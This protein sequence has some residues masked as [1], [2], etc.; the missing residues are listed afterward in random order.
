MQTG[1][2]HSRLTTEDGSLL[3]NRRLALI[4]SVASGKIEAPRAAELIAR[5][6]RSF[7]GSS[8]QGGRMARARLAVLRIRPKDW[9]FPMWLPIPLAL[10]GP[11]LRVSGALAENGHEEVRKLASLVGQIPRCGKLLEVYDE[12]NEVTVWII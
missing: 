6:T 8:G 1:K 2:G 5:D 7:L 10:V 3:R 9:R 4:T 12:G 11:V